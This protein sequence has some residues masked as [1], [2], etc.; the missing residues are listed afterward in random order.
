[1]RCLDG[2]SLWLG[3]VGDL[4]EPARLFAADIRA[5]VELAAN[6]APAQLPREFLHCR[7]PLNDG[8]GNPPWLLRAAITTVTSLIESRVPTLVCCGAGMSRSPAIAAAAIAMDSGEAPGDVLSRIS[9]SGPHDISASLWAD[10]QAVVTSS[11]PA[12]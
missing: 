9:R 3:N 12:S 7:F 5:V 4:R 10:V 6:E 11:R 2:Y 1:M 8:A